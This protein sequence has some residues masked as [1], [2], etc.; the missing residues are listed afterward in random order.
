VMVQLVIVTLSPEM[1]I[2]ENEFGIRTESRIVQFETPGAR[3]KIVL[4]VME[5]TVKESY[6]YGLSSGFS[7]RQPQHRSSPGFTSLEQLWQIGSVKSM[8]S[9][10]QSR[11]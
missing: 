10:Y 9:V 5:E 2:P 8:I 6:S 11:N 7:P 3:V 4:V 1:V